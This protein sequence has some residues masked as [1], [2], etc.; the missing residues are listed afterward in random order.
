MTSG[1]VCRLLDEETLLWVVSLLGVGGVL[2]SV[3]VLSLLWVCRERK[4]G[5]NVEPIKISGWYAVDNFGK[6]LGDGGFFI[7]KPVARRRGNKLFWTGPLFL[8]IARLPRMVESTPEPIPVLL[9]IER[10][11]EP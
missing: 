6:G 4:G 9:T 1:P 5:R 7:E 3:C 11:D 8:P 2:L 10:R